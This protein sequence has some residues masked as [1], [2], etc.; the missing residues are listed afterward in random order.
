MCLAV[1]ANALGNDQTVVRACAAIIV[2]TPICSSLSFSFSPSLLLLSLIFLR[3]S[4]A[5]SM[6]EVVDCG[7]AARKKHR[8]PRKA[9]LLITTNYL[10][11][12]RFSDNLARLRGLYLHTE[13]PYK[14]LMRLFARLSIY[15]HRPILSAK[16]GKKKFVR[17]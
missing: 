11:N 1:C 2:N 8:H 3:E 16:K 17:V 5:L 12:R 14:Y 10:Y 15:T 7:S 13:P 9:R 6:R 4:R